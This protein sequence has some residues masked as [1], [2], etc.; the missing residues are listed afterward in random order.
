MYLLVIC[1]NYFI[2]SKNS[3]RVM[4]RFLHCTKVVVIVMGVRGVWRR[5]ANTPPRQEKLLD[6]QYSAEV[7]GEC[8]WCGVRSWHC[9]VRECGSLTLHMAPLPGP[10]HPRLPLTQTHSPAHGRCC[11]LLFMIYHLGCHAHRGTRLTV[12][13]SLCSVGEIRKQ[14]QLQ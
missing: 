6:C 5:G 2:I 9:K 8:L 3:E 4:R 13:V 1:I 12:I 7:A 14:E 10:P 11:S